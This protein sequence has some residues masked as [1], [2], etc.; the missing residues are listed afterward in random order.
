MKILVLAS[1]IPYPPTDSNRA[2]YYHLLRRFQGRHDVTVLAMS[3]GGEEEGVR[4][5][6]DMVRELIVVGHEVRKTALRR[7]VSFL[8]SRPFGVQ[9]FKSA[10]Y[11]EALR[12]L[13]AREEF[14]VIVAGNVNMAQYTAALTGTPRI[15]FPQDA[16]SLYYRR[17]MQH[18]GN[19]FAFLYSFIQHHKLRRYER[20]MY[21][22]FDA[23]VLVARRDAEIIGAACPELPIYFAYSGVDMPPH[24]EVP[25][26]PNTICFSGVMY[27]P[28]NIDC[29]T[30]F[31]DDVFPLVQR[32]VPEATFHVVGKEPVP[33]IEAMAARPGI[34]VTGRVP[35]VI[36]Y[37]RSMEIY[38]CPMRLGSGMKMKIVEAL[39]AALPVVSTSVGA[40]G[41]DLLEPGR[42]FVV[43]DGAENLAAEIVK[44]LRDPER[45]A[46]L[47]RS[48]RAKVE[49]GY[50]WDAYV[51]AWEDI[52][53]AVVGGEG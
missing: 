5:V 2:C 20:L 14:D 38:V 53:E 7:L 18:A 24:K 12:D 37:I 34:V 42:D 23:C 27:Y 28:P 1:E 41:M 44:L 30:Y 40:D 13:L 32:E 9:I 4:A 15:L 36:E 16:W 52:I 43:A 39:A 48:G 29:V 46:E 33:E 22:R 47:G 31:A 19:P 6:A 51:R 8:S 3:P 17:Q 10:A 11:A 50:T 26:Q 49:S 21:G 35:D 25:K 45:R